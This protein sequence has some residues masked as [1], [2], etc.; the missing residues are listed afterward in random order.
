LTKRDL[1][2]LL[3]LLVAVTGRNVETIKELPSAH[4]ILDDRAVEVRVLKR[5]RGRRRWSETVTWEIGPPGRQLHTPGGLYL[6]VHEL[7]SRSRGFSNSGSLWSSWRNGHR[8][9]V[10]GVAEHF[11]PFGTSLQAHLDA[12]GWIARHGLIVEA[13]PGGDQEDPRTAKTTVAPLCLDFNRLKTSI[14]V[15]RTRELGGHLPSAVRTNTIPVL[16]RNY[17][18]GDPTVVEWAHEIIGGA[19]VDAEQS[20]LAAHQRA[21]QAAGGALQVVSGAA[22]AKRL[23]QAAGLPA[24]TARRTA[25]GELDTAWSACTGHDKH[26]ATGKPCR[27]SFL[28]C[29]HCGNCVITRTHLP[30]LLALLDALDSRRQHLSETDWW[31]RYGMVWAAICR[32]ILTKF[33]PAEIEHATANKPVDALLDLVEAPWEHP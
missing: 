1:V 28:A 21:L 12:P 25:S 14:E 33:S 2:P 18:R 19:L 8:A 5:R 32:D 29:F 13:P 3:V 31:F 4:R 20:A 7:T 11:N 9:Q 16:F 6:L 27:A 26:P 10:S 24:E 22:D 23:E 15:R 17:L 30:R